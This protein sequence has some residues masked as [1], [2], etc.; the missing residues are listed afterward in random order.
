MRREKELSGRLREQASALE[1][2]N[3][4]IRIADARANRSAEELARIR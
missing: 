1:S 4:R 3:S 2:S